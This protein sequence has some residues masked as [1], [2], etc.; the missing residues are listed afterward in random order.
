MSRRVAREK[1]MQ[2]LFQID[3]GSA[4][5]EVAME[6]TLEV[7]ELSPADKDFTRQLVEGTLKNQEVIDQYIQRYALDWGLDRLANV[8]RNI[9]RLALYEM[10]F[11]EDIPVNVSID[12]AIELAKI[13]NSEESGKFVNGV[14]DGI[15]KEIAPNLGR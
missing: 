12:E 6:Q 11:V 13:F 8:D 14:L 4:V 7:T 2:V 15:R 10:M 9:L 5:P 1:A 3:V